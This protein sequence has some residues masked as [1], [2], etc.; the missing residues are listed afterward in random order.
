MLQVSLVRCYLNILLKNVCIE[1]K[2]RAKVADVLIVYVPNSG[3][4]CDWAKLKALR[5]ARSKTE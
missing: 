4:K 5:G 1:M 2:I 3:R